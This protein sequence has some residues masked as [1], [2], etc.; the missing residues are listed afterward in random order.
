MKFAFIGTHGVGKT[1]LAYGLAM[2]L[3]Q[4]GANVGFLEEVARR[5]PFP[6]NEETSLEAQTWILMETIRREIELT[7]V[8]PDLVC[9]RSALDNYCYLEFRFGRHE[10]LFAL[11]EHWASTYDL[12][13]KV[14]IRTEFLHTD[15]TRS[16]DL[17]FQKAI[18]STL[19]QLL[20]ETGIPWVLFTSLEDAVERT[21]LASGRLPIA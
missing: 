3:K 9:D 21:R 13:F 5:C 4:H 19:N 7:Q 17:V 10:S 20:E 14:P 1:T 11:V 12:L 16:T 2:R 15:G 18:D 8:Y 6:I